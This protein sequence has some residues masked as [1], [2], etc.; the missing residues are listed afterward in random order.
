MAGPN[1]ETLKCVRQ[2][3][4]LGG[5]ISCDGKAGNELSRRLGEAG[6]VFDDLQK[7]WLH[8]AIPSRR[9]IEIYTACV[10]SKLLYSLESL[11]LL[12]DEKRRLDAFHYR[13]LRKLQRIPCSYISRISNADVL[14]QGG[15]H[16]LSQSLEQRQKA[17]Y[18]RVAQQT[19]SS[20]VKMVTCDSEGQPIKWSANRRRG[21]PRQR[22]AHSVHK[23]MQT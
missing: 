13:C 12:K 23:L 8:A 11:W 14:K 22:W 19:D 7:I 18:I 10:T 16:T 9:K 17:L 15:A 1:G 3:V 5:L 20:L 6:R 2:A 21:R 4:Y